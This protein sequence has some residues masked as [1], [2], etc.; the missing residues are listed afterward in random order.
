MPARPISHAARPLRT[1]RALR[2]RR[3]FTL[4]EVMIV[5]ALVVALTGL[6]GIALLG[7]RD[8]AKVD[9][10]RIDM[11]TL[12]QALDQFYFDM[13]RW[14][15]DEEGL[16]ALWDRNALQVEDESM[17][18]RWRAYLSEPLAR[19]RWGNEWGYRQVSEQ[20]DE[21][22][23]DLWSNGPDGQ[24]G[25]EDDITSWS[26]DAGGAGGFGDVLGGGN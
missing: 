23:Y 15:T 2:A 5:I 24:E 19:D 8:D 13:N 17:E 16:A 11:N 14:P 3:G 1:V 26:T 18:S 12:R 10:T 22:R 21:S 6:V 25:T 20:G 9:M 4:I 7:R